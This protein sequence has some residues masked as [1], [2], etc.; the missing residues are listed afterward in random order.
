MVR[1]IQKMRLFLNLIIFKKLL[2]GKILLR[3]LLKVVI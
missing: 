2:L 3:F 1:L